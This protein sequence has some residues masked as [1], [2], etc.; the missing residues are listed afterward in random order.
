MKSTRVLLLALVAL[1]CVAGQVMAQANAN[2]PQWRGPNRDGISNETGLLKQWPADGPSLAWNAKGAGNGYSSIVI[3]NGKLYTMGL[4]GDRE[5]VA[6]ALFEV[7]ILPI[8]VFR[9]VRLLPATGL[10]GQF[11]YSWSIC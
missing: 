7:V 4:R 2:W 11:E 6:D 3:S 10:A 9:L 8:G 1:L 5:P